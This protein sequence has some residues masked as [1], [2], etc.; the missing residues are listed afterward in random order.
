MKLIKYAL[1]IFAAFTTGKELFGLT[2][3][4]DTD[5]T[6]DIW[7]SY[8]AS[9]LPGARKSDYTRLKVGERYTVLGS[10]V[11]PILTV[12][13]YHCVGGV[14]AKMAEKKFKVKDTKV[15]K[16]FFEDLHVKVVGGHITAKRGEE[17][18]ETV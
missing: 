5:S 8:G 12:R 6:S 14:G 13:A 17:P 4:N 18:L 11:K 1:V 7:I 9:K 10:Y 15:L 3:K 16:Q 2:V